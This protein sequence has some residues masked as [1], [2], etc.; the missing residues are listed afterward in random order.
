M[1]T[2][3]TDVMVAFWIEIIIYTQKYWWLRSPH[4]DRTYDYTAWQVFPDGTV[5]YG[6]Y[7]TIKYS[8]GRNFAGHGLLLP[9]LSCQPF[10][11][12][13][14]DSNGDAYYSYGYILIHIRVYFR[15]T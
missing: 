15:L 5:G 9:R 13:D 14:Y 4:T 7:G 10:W 6:Y 8:Y 2:V 12:R 3:P 1:S 11:W